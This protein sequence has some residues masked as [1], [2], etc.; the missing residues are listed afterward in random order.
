MPRHDDKQVRKNGQTFSNSSSQ[1]AIVFDTKLSHSDTRF[2]R[3]G[4][5]EA[6]TFIDFS[7]SYDY[8]VS[9][10][11]LCASGRLI[12]LCASGV[13]RPFEIW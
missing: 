6:W 1:W 3:F 10:S 4:Q 8:A 12:F 13:R 9:L 7:F 2:T 5:S 11:S